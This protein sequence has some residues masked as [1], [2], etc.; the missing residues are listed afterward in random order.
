MKKLSFCISF[1]LILSN[2]GYAQQW[3]LGV[4]TGLDF[5][6][7]KFYN[8]DYINGQTLVKPDIGWTFGLSGLYK[9]NENIILQ[10][11]LA[12]TTKQLVPDLNKVDHILES[13]HFTSLEVPIRIKYWMQSFGKREIEDIN[14][15]KRKSKKTKNQTKSF[16]SNAL[17][18]SVVAGINYS[19]MLKVS[20]TYFDD[21]N[22][23]YL[24][25]DLKKLI[26]PE[27]GISFSKNYN[28]VHQLSIDVL[29]RISRN[30]Y[31]FSTKI[32]EKVSLEFNYFYKI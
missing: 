31:E 1:I 5:N 16:Y 27:I 20:P 22:V 8:S 3:Y 25:F 18:L 21:G 13:V 9:T 2:F 10:G 15:K 7:Y 4:C 28:D 26:Y 29:T 23:I 14:F 11:G 12:I 6:L 24:P 17:Q 32:V 19:Q 30:P